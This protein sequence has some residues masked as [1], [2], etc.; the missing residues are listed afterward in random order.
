M[1][2]D[3][4]RVPLTPDAPN[5]KDSAWHR[6]LIT[7]GLAKRNAIDERIAKAQ[8]AGRAARGEK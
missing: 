6:L 2:H 8:E 5:E 1:T 7:L 4:R 3:D